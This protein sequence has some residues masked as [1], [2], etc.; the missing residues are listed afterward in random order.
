V[1]E[2]DDTPEMDLH[3]QR[4]VECLDS[5]NP[6]LQATHSRFAGRL[7]KVVPTDTW[8]EL[9]GKWLCNYSLKSCRT[10]EEIL[11][12]ECAVN[13][14]TTYAEFAALSVFHIAVRM[15]TRP[16]GIVSA[17][18]AHDVEGERVYIG[19]KTKTVAGSA[20]AMLSDD[21]VRTT[22][23]VPKYVVPGLAQP[24]RIGGAFDPIHVGHVA[25]AEAVTKALKLQEVLFIPTGN[26]PTKTTCATTDHRLIM[27]AK[28]TAGRAGFTVCP[29]E[30]DAVTSGRP[31]FTVDTVRTLR[32][33]YAAAGTPVILYLIL[34][35][36]E[37]AALPTWHEI[38][39]LA[40]LVFFVGIMRKSS[41]P[42]ATKARS[43]VCDVQRPL[44]YWLL[45]SPV[46]VSSTACRHAAATGN[47]DTLNTLVDPAVAAYIVDKGL[48]RF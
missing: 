19:R 12:G 37:V 9:N 46:D 1:G 2:E 40:K 45:F 24:M 42:T 7:L 5:V 33:Q 22:A 15:G 11:E 16:L 28:A 35:A 14:H 25:I 39:E 44:V 6:Q 27:T 13:K 26:H 41:V 32:A 36:D 4:F 8:K 20:F 10:A 29:I 43:A 3:Y 18:F 47:I 30:V 17:E 38:W 34:G 21:I 31:G 48:Y 23:L